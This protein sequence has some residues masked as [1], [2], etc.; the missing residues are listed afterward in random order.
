MDPNIFAT[1]GALAVAVLFAEEFIDRFWNLDGTAS[2]VRTV[3]LGFAFGLVGAYFDLGMFAPE[4]GL[5]CSY[6]DV[7]CG[8]AIG[9]YAAILANLVFLTPL[10]KAI[11][12][13]LKIRPKE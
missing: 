10:A 2:Q 3:V 12:E 6:G 11:L 4:A 7:V 9:G 5:I 1:V 13:L 8:L